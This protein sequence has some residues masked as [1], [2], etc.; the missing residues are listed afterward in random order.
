MEWDPFRLRAHNR[1]DPAPQVCGRDPRGVSVQRPRVPTRSN[2]I[3]GRSQWPPRV[4]EKRELSLVQI[5]FNPLGFAQEVRSMLIGN[6]N[7]FFE[8]FHDSPGWLNSLCFSCFRSFYVSFFAVFCL[9]KCFRAKLLT[10]YG[11][12]IKAAWHFCFCQNPVIV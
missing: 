12:N 6:L 5:F 3:P 1:Q 10:F 2:Q 4:H 7:E 8:S 11:V 9:S